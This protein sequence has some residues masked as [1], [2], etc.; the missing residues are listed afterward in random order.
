[1]EET[2]PGERR[3][4]NML[5]LLMIAFAPAF[6]DSLVRIKSLPIPMMKSMNVQHMSIFRYD[7]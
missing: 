1:M 5:A 2:Q 3:L 6:I 7:Y 4:E